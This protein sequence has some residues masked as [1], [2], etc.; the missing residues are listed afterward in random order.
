MA[1]NINWSA[2]TEEAKKAIIDFKISFAEKKIEDALHREKVKEIDDNY[3]ADSDKMQGELDVLNAL[4][5]KAVAEKNAEER[6]AINAKKREK[7]LEMGN[8]K[9]EYDNSC[10]NEVARHKEE[11]KR[12]TEKKDKAYALLIPVGVTS[13]K[14]SEKWDVF[15]QA[16]LNYQTTFD[17][18]VFGETITT[19][20]KAVGYENIAENVGYQ[21]SVLKRFAAKIGS[22]FVAGEV[23]EMKPK[24]FVDMFLSIFA[25][26]LVA[27]KQIDPE[28]F[29]LKIAKDENAETEA[30]QTEATEDKA[31]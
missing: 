7:A 31:E 19:F 15:Y 23:V 5:K 1:K 18:T 3:R 2:T 30:T 10:K 17:V 8:R 27:Y 21:A 9:G 24:A 20:L 16:Y 29:K 13:K 26:I 6:A 28:D 4:Y 14:Q 22:K 11:N 12:I 25:E